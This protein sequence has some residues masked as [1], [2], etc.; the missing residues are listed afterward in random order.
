[1]YFNIFY[2]LIKNA[3]LKFFILGVNV[4]YIYG[5]NEYR[6]CYYSVLKGV[7]MYITLGGT[8]I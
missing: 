7:N 5:T 3:F 1:M 2:F 4:F 8:N 6:M